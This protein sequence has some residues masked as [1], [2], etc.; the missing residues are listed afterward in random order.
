MYDEDEQ[1]SISKV[2]S[3]NGEM[4]EES[5][6]LLWE[7]F[8]GRLCRFAEQKVY[9][10][11]RRLIDPEDIAGSAMLALMEGIKQGRFHSLKNRDQLWQ[12][13]IIIAARKTINKSRFLDSE[14]RGGKRTY[15][16]SALGDG[17]LDKL[18]KYIDKTE[19]PAKFVEI[20]MT[21]RELLLALPTDKYRS[22]ALM[23]LAGHSNREIGK[24]LQCSTR[25]INRH[26]EAI[27]EVW[28]DMERHDD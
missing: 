18:A 22:I 28:N 25:T 24:S 2:I 21:C 14:K 10:R 12:M 16:E 3:Q 9:P 5:A 6:Q 26:L 11:H 23:R 20:E 17:G 8:F 13:L 19:D 4:T 15:G 27:R 7:R 1:G